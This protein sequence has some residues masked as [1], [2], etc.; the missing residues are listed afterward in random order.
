MKKILVYGMSND[1]GGIQSFFL[2]LIQYSDND[3]VKYDFVLSSESPVK[4]ASQIKENKGEIFQITP[5][6]KNPVNHKKQ[7]KEILK[8]NYYDFIWVNTT[9][10][11]N[12]TVFKTV[13]RFSDAQLIIHAHGSAFETRNKGIKK[14]IL[15]LLHKFNK[16]KLKKYGDI[17][18]AVS[19]EAAKWLFDD[20]SKSNGKVTIINNGIDTKQYDFN[21]D[22]RNSIR[23]KLQLNDSLTLIQVGRIEKVKNHF[24][25]LEVL[26]ALLSMNKT[27]QLL[28]VGTG[29][30]EA[31]VKERTEKLNIAD[32]V[33]FLGYRT[34]I[35]DYLMAA[36]CLILPSFSEGLPLTVV[37]AQ[38]SGLKSVVSSEAVPETADVTGLVSFLSLQEPAETWAKEIFYTASQ[39]SRE[40][41]LE[42]IKHRGFDVAQTVKEV[43]QILDI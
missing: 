2:N 7:L 16:Q 4:Y 14:N 20:T 37:E 25:T 17:Y 1:Y 5:W 33:E 38:A 36:D 39:Y 23:K 35:E 26:K 42:N 28:V 10:A 13:K 8:T 19:E 11:S 30:L 15:N 32:H 9:S 24:F 3:Y 31:E 29:G 43:N 12:L 21:L 27:S 6:G 41:Q 40:S 22:I 34:N 18:F